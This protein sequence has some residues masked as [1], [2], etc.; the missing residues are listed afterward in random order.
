MKKLLFLCALGMS[1][2]ANAQLTVFE[3]GN[4]HIGNDTTY[5]I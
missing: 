3:N 1:L 5:Y 4:V 2:C